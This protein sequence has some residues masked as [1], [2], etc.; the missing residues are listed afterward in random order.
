MPALAQPIPLPSGLRADLVGVRREDQRASGE[1][2]VILRL[3][4]PDLGD[5]AAA[6]LDD[7][8]WLC[9]TMGLRAADRV[10]GQIAAVVVMLSDRPVPWG[11]ADP[12][13]VQY[14]NSYRV[15]QGTCAPDLF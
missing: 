6:A 13:A 12:D 10:A 4:A 15:G 11:E 2:W 8:D 3:V 7:L 9:R 14:V 5:D 1:T